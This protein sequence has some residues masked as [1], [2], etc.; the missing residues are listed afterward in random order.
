MSKLL[1]YIFLLDK[2]PNDKLAQALVDNDSKLNISKDG[3]V[4]INFES[5]E[6]QED[7]H[8]LIMDFKDIPVEKT[9]GAR[10]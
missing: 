7:L 6:V 8:R 10:A 3:V 2:K 5:P 9:R 1:R 4:S